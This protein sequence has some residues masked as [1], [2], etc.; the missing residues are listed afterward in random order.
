MGP[1][2]RLENMTAVEFT[3]DLQAIGEVN[4]AEDKFT[5]HFDAGF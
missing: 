2:G 4:P 1:N 3:V 5:V